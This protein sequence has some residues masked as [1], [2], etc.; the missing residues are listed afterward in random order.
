MQNYRYPSKDQS[1]CKSPERNIV[2]CNDRSGYDEL[3]CFPLAMAYVPWQ[4]W[5]ALYEADKGFCRGTIF[6]QLDKPFYGMGGCTK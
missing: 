5:C 4:K 2:C 1:R 6:E 3:S